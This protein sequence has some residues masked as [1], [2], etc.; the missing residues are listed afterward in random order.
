MGTYRLILAGLVLYAHAFGRIYGFNPGIVAVISFFV[1]SGYVMSKL[2][3]K[4]YSTLNDV[5]RFYLDR[6]IRLFPQYLFYLALTLILAVTIGFQ[7]PYFGKIG[8]EYILA[9]ALM[10]PL[11]Y[12]QFG[13]INALYVPPAWS[14]GLELTFYLVFPFFCLL[15]QRIKFAVLGLSIIVAS[16]AYFGI[17]NTDLFGYR[18]LPGTFFIFAAGASLGTPKAIPSWFACGCAILFFLAFIWLFAV[19]HLISLPYNKEVMLGGLIGIVA[20]SLLERLPRI[21][22]DDYLGNL[23]YGLFLSHYLFIF[24]ADHYGIS[25]WPIVPLGALAMTILTY[26]FIE[27]P[28]LGW[29]HGLRKRLRPVMM[30]TATPQHQSPQ[31]S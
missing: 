27:R 28:V 31:S 25:R 17:I 3:T 14:L 23:S 9:N 20:V 2:V 10:L 16:L 24:V 11:G 5:P 22:W 30:S 26:Q 1:I 18:F 19:P 21:G 12:Y 8:A 15:H 13:L 6:A 4:S 7:D 29:R